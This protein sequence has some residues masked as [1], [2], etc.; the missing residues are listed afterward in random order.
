LCRMPPDHG[1]CKEKLQQRWFYNPKTKRCK[2]FTFKGCKANANNFKTPLECQEKCPKG[3][4]CRLPPDRG[5]CK[6]KMQRWFYDPKNK[7]CK[8]FTFTGCKA[9]A[10]HFKTRA[11]CQRKCPKRGTP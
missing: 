10:N 7:R 5:P 3:D 2:R 9:N 11:E 4:I 6:E 1:P 8:K